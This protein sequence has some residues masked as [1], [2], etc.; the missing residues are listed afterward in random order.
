LAEKLLKEEQEAFQRNDNDEASIALIKKLQEEDSRIEQQSKSPHSQAINLQPQ[1]KENLIHRTPISGPNSNS[2][3]SISVTNSAKRELELSDFLALPE[4]GKLDK[5]TATISLETNKNQR[6]KGKFQTKQADVKLAVKQMMSINPSNSDPKTSHGID[7]KS[8][9]ATSPKVNIKSPT[10]TSTPTPTPTSFPK[11]NKLTKNSLDGGDKPTVNPLNGIE[12]DELGRISGATHNLNPLAEGRTDARPDSGVAYREKNWLDLVKK[13]Q[14]KI[15]PPQIPFQDKISL[16]ERQNTIS[17]AQT[18]VNPSSKERAFAIDG[19]DSVQED[20]IRPM[21]I[22]F[23]II[24]IP[25]I[26]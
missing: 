19:S 17:R 10:S 16:A 14:D 8:N 21:M 12:V 9:N 4:N 5:I 18:R 1:P 2:S 11:I 22:R 26:D 25:I 6:F 13:S 24:S 23:N 3:I 7:D 20:F 15:G